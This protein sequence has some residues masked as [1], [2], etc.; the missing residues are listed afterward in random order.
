MGTWPRPV[1]FRP[2]VLAHIRRSHLQDRLGS[3][4]LPELLR[5]FHAA[6]HLLDHALDRRTADRQ[7]QPAV[8]RIV[9][10]LPIVLHIPQRLGRELPRIIIRAPPWRWSQLGAA[11]PET[12]QQP[13]DLT[14]PRLTQPP[15]VQGPGGR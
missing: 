7:T 2:A 14:G 3:P 8:T 5:P 15:L 1:A 13:A 6:V 9:H 4:V 10:P 11:C 12:G